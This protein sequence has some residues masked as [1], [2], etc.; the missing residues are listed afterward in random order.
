M[1]GLAA[2]FGIPLWRNNPGTL[3]PASQ[4]LLLEKGEKQLEGDVSDEELAV[5]IRRLKKRIGAGSSSFNTKRTG[6]KTLKRSQLQ[7][8]LQILINLE[9]SNVS[10]TEIDDR[11]LYRAAKGGGAPIDMMSFGG[12]DSKKEDRHSD[13]RQ[14]R[15]HVFQ[16]HCVKGVFLPYLLLQEAQRQLERGD[17]SHDYVYFTGVC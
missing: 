12:A 9:A 14:P 3:S 1:A 2:K 13:H 16:F 5:E 8:V 15:L 11:M 6:Q 17:W 10:V 7:Q 4:Q